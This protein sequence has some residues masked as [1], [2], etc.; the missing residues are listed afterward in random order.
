MSDVECP[1]CGQN[2]EINHDDGYGYEEGVK[3]EQECSNCEKTF[4]FETSIT[5][6]YDA[7]KAPCL[8]DGEHEYKPTCTIP[9]EYTRMR[10]IYCGSERA[11]TEVE[12]VKHSIPPLDTN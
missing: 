12:R 5:F 6:L 3:H 9:K 2:Q 1:Y 10:C 7:A 8:N 11:L 4:V